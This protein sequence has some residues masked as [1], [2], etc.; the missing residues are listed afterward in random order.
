[1]ELRLCWKKVIDATSIF[2]SNVCVTGVCKHLFYYRDTTYIHLQKSNFCYCL[3][4][5]AKRVRVHTVFSFFVY[6]WIKRKTEI[7]LLHTVF[8]CSCCQ[9]KQ[10]ENQCYIPFIVFHSNKQ[11]TI[12]RKAVLFPNPKQTLM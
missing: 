11:N 1:M 3:G 7:K 5:T 4:P 8:R 6:K 9:I 12:Q 10:N 2:V